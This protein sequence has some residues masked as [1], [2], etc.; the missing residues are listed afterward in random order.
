MGKSTKG[1]SI[2]LLSGAFLGTL[3]G[4]LYAP[5]KGINTRDRL[6]YQLNNYIDE[7]SDLIERLRHENQISDAKKEG[8]LV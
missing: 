8:D 1:F 7:I 3:I 6:S 4:M 2:G 5:D